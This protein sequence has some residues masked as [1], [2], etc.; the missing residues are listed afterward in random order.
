LSLIIVFEEYPQHLGY[1]E[2]YLS[3]KCVQDDAG[4][5]PCS[6]QELRFKKRA[7]EERCLF[8]SAQG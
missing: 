1:G 6:C 8:Y 4:N 7:G 2:Y 5:R 3:M